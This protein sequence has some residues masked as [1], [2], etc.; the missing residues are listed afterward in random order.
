MP[1]RKRSLSLPPTT[2]K[3]VESSTGAATMESYYEAL[4]WACVVCAAF[5]ETDIEMRLAAAVAGRF[6]RLF[7]FSID[8]LIVDLRR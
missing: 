2:T 4:E 7:S 3:V 1:W 6:G 5:W 8:G